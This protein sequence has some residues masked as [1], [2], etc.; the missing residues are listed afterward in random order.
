MA[1]HRLAVDVGGTFVD[2]VLFNEAT[3]VITL[4]KVP[5]SGQLEKRFFEG[6]ERLGLDLADLASIVHGST[7]VINTIVQEKGARVGLITTQGF[8]DVPPISAHFVSMRA[9]REVFR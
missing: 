5:S 6:L 1:D 4:E 9:W 7:T 3:G 2:L 8:R